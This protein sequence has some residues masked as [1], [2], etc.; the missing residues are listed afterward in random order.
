M[1]RATIIP[2]YNEG[3]LKMLD[4]R[5]QC[6]ALKLKWIKYIK[7]QHTM[8]S[9]D[10]WYTWITKC[11]PNIDILD[12]L[13]CNLN[14]KDMNTICKRQSASFWHEL[15]NNWSKWNFNPHPMTREYIIN[16]PIWFNSLIKIGGNIVFHRKWYNQGIFTIRQ[17][18]VNNR[19]ITVQK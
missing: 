7:E 3:G 6:K 5:A 2:P 16:Q 1:K 13:H 19:W 10:F 4:S 14:A 9:Q 12:F 18:R 8:T 11:I 17:L 15:L